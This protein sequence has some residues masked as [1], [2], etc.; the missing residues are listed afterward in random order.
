M[1][2]IVDNWSFDPFV[3]VAAVVVAL[4]ELG[5]WRLSRH[6]APERSRLRRKRSL[7]FYAGVVLLL[8]AVC[9]PLEYW[10]YDYFFVHMIEH[11]VVMFFVPILVVAGAPWL[12]LLHALPPRVRRR[13]VRQT[14]AAG[15]APMRSVWRFVS[16]PWAA[17]LAFN[18]V[19]VFWHLPGPFDFAERTFEVHVWLMYGSY[20]AAGVLFWLQI[21]S[22]Q[23]FRRRSSAV[24]QIG[25]IVS[26]N[27]VMFVLAMA[28]SIFTNH[29][30]YAVYANRPGVTLSP[31]ADQQLGAA[32]LWVCGDFW[33]VPSLIRVVKRAIDEE[34]SLSQLLDAM[35][36]RSANGWGH[37]GSPDGSDRPV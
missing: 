2:Y 3:V 14:A 13:V 17:V 22:S 24:W 12:P 27:V 6:A 29:S 10:S 9:S 35:M 20:L 8:L 4:H 34:G 11:I 26:T 18:A 23:P 36:G 37:L 28:L 7:L 21:V 16:S 15:F 33:A 19:M 32:I 1:S 30:W 31:F 25:A 5:L